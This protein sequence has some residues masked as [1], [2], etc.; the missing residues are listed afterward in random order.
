MKLKK[1]LQEEKWEK[2]KHLETKNMLLK[3]NRSMIKPKEEIRK[4]LEANENV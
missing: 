1:Q 2:H 4:Y 3:A